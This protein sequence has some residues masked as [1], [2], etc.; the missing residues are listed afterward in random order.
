MI[1]K[2]PNKEAETIYKEIQ[3]IVSITL[4]P[5]ETITSDNGTEFSLHES[6]TNTTV[7]YF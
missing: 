5:F 4:L 1:R 6:I 3:N 2:I 7:A